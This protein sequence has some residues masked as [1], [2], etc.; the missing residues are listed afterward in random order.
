MHP[1]TTLRYGGSPV[2]LRGALLN[3][4]DLWRAAGHPEHLRPADWLAREDTTRLRVRADTRWTGPV[5]PVAFQAGDAAIW[6]TDTD[7]LVATTLTDDRTTWAHWQLALPYTRALSPALHRWCSAVLA[8][9]VVPLE[10]APDPL[11]RIAR[12]LRRIQHRLDTLDRHAADLMFLTLSSQQ[13]VL[14]QRRAFSTVS[15]ASIIRAVAAEPY[16]GQCPCCGEARVLDEA[17]RPVAGAEFDHA[18]HRG[19]NRPEHGWLVCAGC[20]G[21]LTHS[22]Y[23]FRFAR[24]PAFRAFQARVLEQRRR[25]RQGTGDQ[26]R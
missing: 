4:A 22:G 13:L 8:R 24:L 3:L 14:G 9:R 19:L 17:S 1:I 18:F 2:R 12:Q 15:R 26:P 21:D 6:S 5:G 7:G 16:G 10:M 11:A 20:H 23:L 25:A